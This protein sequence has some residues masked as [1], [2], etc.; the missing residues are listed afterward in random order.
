M[1]KIKIRGI[2][3]LTVFTFIHGLADAMSGPSNRIHY[4]NKYESRFDEYI[5]E[6]NKL[7]HKTTADL[8]IQ[9]ETL[10]LKINIENQKQYDDDKKFR[11]ENRMF[12]LKNQLNVCEKNIEKIQEV[13][14]NEILKQRNKLISKI[15]VYHKG[16][17]LIYKDLLSFNKERFK[18]D[19]FQKVINYENG[20]GEI[21]DVY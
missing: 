5:N 21:K 9:R 19:N 1:K 14:L 4:L 7:F 16:A 6:Y 17:N 10:N 15:C 12:N 8:I 13:Y 3:H 2:N 11:E 18:I 20:K